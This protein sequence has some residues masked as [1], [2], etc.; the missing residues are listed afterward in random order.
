[1][2]HE[3]LCTKYIIIYTYD[4][5]IEDLELLLQNIIASSDC[6]EQQTCS[7]CSSYQI[8]IKQL[9]LQTQQFCKQVTLMIQPALL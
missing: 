3:I 2:L 8:N 9:Q 7:K 1:M 4:V 6:P 5:G